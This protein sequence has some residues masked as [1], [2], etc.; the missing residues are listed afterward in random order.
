MKALRR[1]LSFLRHLLLYGLFAVY[2]SPFFLVLINS[3]KSRREILSNPFGLPPAWS[4]Q[5]FT[6]AFQR[7][8]FVPAFMNSL[9][10]TVCSV[11]GIAVFSAM[12]AYLFV[13][14]DWRFNKLMFFAMVASML[15]PF[16]AIMIPLVRI[17]GGLNL[18]NNRWI[19]IYMYLG[20][21]SSFAVFLYH[22][23]IKSIP[24]ELEEAAMIDGC[25]R[26]QVFFLVVFPLLKSTTL[27]LIILNVLWIWNDFLLPSLV[28]IS[29]NNRTLPLTTFYFHGTY[30]SDYGLL[31]AA[32]MLTILPVIIF[33]TG[34]QKHI[35]RGVMEGAIK[36]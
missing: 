11:I 2:L 29:A 28:L 4:L 8:G 34:L 31:M 19:L 14:T 36:A 5:N 9:V 15:I 30:T 20:F 13:R 25:S 32:L 23:F 26:L 3:F 10:I 22:G 6:T 17:Y 1:A 18:L 33:Y 21:G 16:Q 7:M 27:S 35:I 24:K 12:T